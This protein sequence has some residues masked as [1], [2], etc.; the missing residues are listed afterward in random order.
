MP[1]DNTKFYATF[2]TNS[3]GILGSAICTFDIKDINAAFDG[4]YCTNMEIS[5]RNEERKN[6]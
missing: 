5:E 1:N 4:K 3:H 6:E 2:T